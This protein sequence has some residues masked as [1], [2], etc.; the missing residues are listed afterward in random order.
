M[1]GPVHLVPASREFAQGRVQRLHPPLQRPARNRHRAM[2][3]RL[4]PGVKSLL[5]LNQV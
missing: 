4:H 1:R 5:L 3:Q 2:R